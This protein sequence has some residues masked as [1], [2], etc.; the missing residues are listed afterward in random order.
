MATHGSAMFDSYT[1]N[2]RRIYWS[3]FID[4]QSQM[5]RGRDVLAASVPENLSEVESLSPTFE[6]FRH[7]MMPGS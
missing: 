3:E 5:S 7:R 2:L 6:Y 1:R 4:V